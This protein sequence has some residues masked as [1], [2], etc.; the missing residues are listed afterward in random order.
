MERN[1]QRK[2]SETE[3]EIEIKTEWASLLSSQSNCT[4]IPLHEAVESGHKATKE[5]IDQ[6][7]AFYL[8]NIFSPDECVNLLEVAESYGFGYTN[9]PK[10][11][12][13]NLRLITTDFTLATK[14]W[15]RVEPFVP[16]TL[17]CG[18]ETWNVVGLNECWRL[19]KYRTGDVFRSHCDAAFARDRRERSFYTVN[20]YM[21]TGFQVSPFVFSI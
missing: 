2:I 6:Y 20:I 16:K 4:L 19:A 21:N 18:G 10:S 13:G 1:V 17:I 9:Y 15:S 8:R 3:R 7:N 14:V 12:R 11:Y 5:T